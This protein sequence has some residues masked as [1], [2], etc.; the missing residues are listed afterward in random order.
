MLQMR[1][2]VPSFVSHA[3]LG[4]SAPPALARALPMPVLQR[5]LLFVPAAIWCQRLTLGDN[6]SQR[7]KMAV[8]SVEALVDH[9]R[10]AH[11]HILANERPEAE[12]RTAPSCVA[13]PIASSTGPAARLLTWQ[14]RKLRMAASPAS[15]S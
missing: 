4:A 2:S 7:A 12:R 3:R 13:C 14:V 11:A 9:P 8:V 10:A 5:T 1:L 6:T 15:V